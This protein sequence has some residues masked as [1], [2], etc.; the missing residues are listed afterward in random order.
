MPPG[1]DHNGAMSDG[2]HVLVQAA[3]ARLQPLVLCAIWRETG[4]APV[5]SRVH[6]N[7]YASLNL[8]LDGQVAAADGTTWPERF[9]TG[10]FTSPLATVAQGPLRSVCLVF[11][12]WLLYEVFGLRP[13]ALADRVHPLPQVLGPP[14]RSWLDALASAHP[15]DESLWPALEAALP[16]GAHDCSGQLALPVLRSQGAS[17]AASARGLG[18]R[19]YRRLFSERLGLAPKAWVR[20]QRFDTLARDLANTP[21][22]SGLAAQAGYADQAHMTRETRAVAGQ[23]PARL[24]DGLARRDP[25]LWSLRPAEVRFVQDGDPAAS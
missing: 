14:A 9:L 7:A 19:H 10:P 1:L 23:P 21:S 24:R 16:P 4:D 13:P 11:Q 22:L 15:G 2:E 20:L 5:A 8:V 17:A 18:E 3:P 6:A 12:P 25:A